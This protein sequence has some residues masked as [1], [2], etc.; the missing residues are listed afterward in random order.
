[1][2]Y[3]SHVV[4]GQKFPSE[5]GNVRWC[6]IVVQQPLL[7]WPKFGAKSLHNFTQSLYNVTA[8]RRIGCLACQD[9]FFVNSP[10]NLKENDEHSLNFALQLS[11]MP[12][13]HPCMAHAFFP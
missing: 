5:K 8:V 11:H 12:F 3:D 10:L 2:G 7:L 9:K 4:L 1:M 13:E 6:T